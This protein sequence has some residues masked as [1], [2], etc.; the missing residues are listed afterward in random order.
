MLDAR[1]P[2]RPPGSH[3]PHRR[4]TRAAVDGK[5][6]PPRR[7]LICAGCGRLSDMGRFGML[8]EVG[9]RVRT[10]AGYK[11]IAWTRDDLHASERAA[12]V[13]QFRR[14]LA[15]LEDDSAEE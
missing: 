14:A 2:G 10:T 4:G 11:R 6:S 5:K 8:H 13:A 9:A 3:T 15:S 12:L 1:K 7:F